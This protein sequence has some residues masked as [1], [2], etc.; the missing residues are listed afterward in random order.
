MLGLGL[1]VIGV[2][3]PDAAGIPP[4]FQ[5]LPPIDFPNPQGPRASI[6]LRTWTQSTPLNLLGQDTFYGGPGMGAKAFDYPNPRGYIPA[7]DLKTWAWGTPLNLLGK[8]FFYGVGGPTY[9]YP[10]PRGYRQ[11]IDNLTLTNFGPSLL[12]F[13]PTFGLAGIPNFDQPN[14][15]RPRPLST[16]ITFTNPTPIPIIIFPGLPC[17]VY[18]VDQGVI[19]VYASDSPSGQGWK[20]AGYMAKYEIDTSI[21][22]N[23]D[24]LNAIDD[25]YVDSSGVTLFILDPSGVQTFFQYTGGPASPIIRD[26]QG[27]YHYVITPSKSGTWT[28]KWQATGS[29]IGTSPDTFFTVNA[30][31]LI[32]G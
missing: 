6:D 21:Q 14:P 28:Y 1:V 18:S 19:S 11:P 25:I 12:H 32:A 22:I 15:Q 8:D 13:T 29:F 4:A 27:H 3:A 2:A 23:G 10:N 31:A 17:L 9:D 7:I 30:S 26:S 20:G 24:F 5:T 16:L